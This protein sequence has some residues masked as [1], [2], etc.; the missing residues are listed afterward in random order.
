[1]DE[2]MALELVLAVERTVADSTLERLVTAVDHH[3]HF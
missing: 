1:V 2:Q 3:M